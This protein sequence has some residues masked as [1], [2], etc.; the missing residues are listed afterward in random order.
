[1]VRSCGFGLHRLLLQRQSLQRVTDK[2]ARDAAYAIQDEPC[3]GQEG[4]AQ[5]MQATNSTVDITA[6]RRS[7]APPTRSGSNVSATRRTGSTSR[8][9]LVKRSS[10]SSSRTS[11]RHALHSD[12]GS[13]PANCQLHSA[14]TPRCCFR[15]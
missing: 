3:R 9:S 13:A 1:M 15:R 7:S 14:A 4:A 10:K 12:V 11:T 2:A 5:G 6:Q 8:S